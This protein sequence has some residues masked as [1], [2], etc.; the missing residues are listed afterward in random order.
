MYDGF[1]A[2]PGLR[3]LSAASILSFM[4]LSLVFFHMLRQ[5]RDGV[6]DQLSISATLLCGMSVLTGTMLVC[7]SSQ[8]GFFLALST[9]AANAAG[10]I[11]VV[12]IFFRQLG[13]GL[14]AVN[15]SQV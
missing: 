13:R 3:V 10:L 11:V 15:P 2:V 14:S 9:L 6:T 12:C 8:L 4:V 5:E 7:A 1:M